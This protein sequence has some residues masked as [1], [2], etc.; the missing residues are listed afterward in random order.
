MVVPDKQAVSCFGTFRVVVIIVS[1]V[2]TVVRTTVVAII[3]GMAI[4]IVASKVV[5]A[6]KEV[7]GLRIA[8]AEELVAASSTYFIMGFGA[9]TTVL[10]TNAKLNCT[11]VITHKE[12]PM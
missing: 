9:S 11:R 8:T 2:A 5:T 12:F 7:V 3:M 10:I 1:K 4:I 6:G